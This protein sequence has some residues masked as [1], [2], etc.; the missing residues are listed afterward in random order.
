MASRIVNYLLLFAA[1][2]LT[3]TVGTIAQQSTVAIF[4]VA[5][6]WGEILG[7]LAIGLLLAGL[8]LVNDSRWFALS[9]AVGVLIPIGVFSLQSAGGS[10]LI[11]NDS[12]GAA[13]LWG[14]VIICVILVAAP[15]LPRRRE[16]D[17]NGIS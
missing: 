15:G 1:G 17:Q 5:V 2:L 10:V 3:G 6:P 13:W 14:A 8:R 7:L 4:N 12:L 11:P 9:A 16:A